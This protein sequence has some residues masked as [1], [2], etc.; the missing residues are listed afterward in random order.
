MRIRS[1]NAQN[2]KTA[3]QIA[4]ERRESERAAKLA[5]LRKRGARLQREALSAERT[6][7][8]ACNEVDKLKRDRERLQKALDSLD[9]KIA[10]KQAALVGKQRTMNGKFNRFN[11]TE[12]A[13]AK[14]TPRPKEYDLLS[15]PRKATKAPAEIALQDSS[16]DQ[17]LDLEI[18]Q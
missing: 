6:Y 7:N 8:D 1:E 12:D 4:K 9:A 14:K 18:A 11:S 5:D 10:R 17:A 2:R 16:T 15:E 13:I 3:A